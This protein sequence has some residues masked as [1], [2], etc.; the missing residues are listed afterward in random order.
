MKGKIYC[1]CGN[2]VLYE[3]L[4]DED[5]YIQENDEWVEAVR[6]KMWGNNSPLEFVRNKEEFKIKFMV[7]ADKK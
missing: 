5:L 1:H 6:Y 3:V 7:Y 4:Q 2:G